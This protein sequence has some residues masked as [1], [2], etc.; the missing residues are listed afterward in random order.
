MKKFLF[1]ILLFVI[2]MSLVLLTSCN[3][4]SNKN[5]ETSSMLDPNHEHIEVVDPMVWPTCQS[6]GWTEGR[7]CVECGEITVSQ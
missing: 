5:N 3:K 6:V 7:H 1:G 2:L 4:D